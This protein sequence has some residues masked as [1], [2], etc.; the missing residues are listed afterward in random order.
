MTMQFQDF[1]SDPA[2]QK[3]ALQMLYRKNKATQ[4]VLTNG[5]RDGKYP[6]FT[7]AAS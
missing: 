4:P 6:T 3:A 5:G 7:L 2:L 1:T